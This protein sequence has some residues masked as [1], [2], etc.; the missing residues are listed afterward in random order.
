[1]YVT[2]YTKPNCPQCEQTKR[3]LDRLGV[4]YAA[5]DLSVN[6]LERARLIAAGHRSAPVV[7]SGMGSWAGHRPE[8]IRKLGGQ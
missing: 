1:M 8:M 4:P 5:I 7:E 6:E 2:V 3:E